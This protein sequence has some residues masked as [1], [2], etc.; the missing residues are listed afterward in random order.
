MSVIR[1]PPLHE[2]K[3]ISLEMEVCLTFVSLAN[4]S[5]SKQMIFFSLA[6]FGDNY[7]SQ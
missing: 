4:G 2:G 3:K 7:V 6:Y 1:R 5:F